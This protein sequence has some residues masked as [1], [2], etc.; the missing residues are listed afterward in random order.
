[1]VAQPYAGHPLAL[2][3]CLSNLGEN[4]IRYGTRAMIELVLKNLSAGGL[5]AILSLPRQDN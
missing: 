2:R 1:M 3:R 4:A 5:K